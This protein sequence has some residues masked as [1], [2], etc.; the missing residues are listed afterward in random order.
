MDFFFPSQR[1]ASFMFGHYNESECAAVGEDDGT[2]AIVLARK[3]IQ[4]SGASFCCFLDWGTLLKEHCSSDKHICLDP[5]SAYSV[6]LK[7]KLTSC[8]I[9]KIFDPSPVS[10]TC[11]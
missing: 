11:F 6:V 9:S 7:G 10:E 1:K 5:S 2:R 3:T 8:W 4:F